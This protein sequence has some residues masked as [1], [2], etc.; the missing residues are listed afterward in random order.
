[1]CGP[2]ETSEGPEVTTKR[3]EVD[4]IPVSI[5]LIVFPLQIR[6]T[7]WDPFESTTR[8]QLA[9]LREKVND[10][11]RKNQMRSTSFEMALSRLE[12]LR[13]NVVE[14][15]QVRDKLKESVRDMKEKVK[16][17]DK[18]YKE[19]VAPAKPEPQKG[20]TITPQDNGLERNQAKKSNEA[21]KDVTKS[22]K[23]RVLRFIK[24]GFSLMADSIVLG[25]M[26]LKPAKSCLLLPVPY[27]QFVL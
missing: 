18:L 26:S 11:R 20:R 27:T 7:D 19:E 22:A 21:R 24:S 16:N 2:S 8:R 5:H 3:V 15:R 6:R 17:F 1:M 4:K 25:Y 23:T 9:N 14:L 10:L 12:G 13:R